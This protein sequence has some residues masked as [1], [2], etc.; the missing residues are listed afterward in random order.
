M[1]LQVN[2]EH[3]DLV[4]TGPVMFATTLMELIFM[5]LKLLMVKLMTAL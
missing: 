1:K 4:T 5:V 2:Q 3:F